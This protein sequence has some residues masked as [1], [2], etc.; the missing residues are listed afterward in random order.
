[1]PLRAGARARSKKIETCLTN[2]RDDCRQIVCKR[3]IHMLLACHVQ[4][5]N[6]QMT[7]RFYDSS[8]DDI[9]RR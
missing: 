8:I 9:Y 6:V 1:M 3:E 4:P 7:D 5:Q 2:T